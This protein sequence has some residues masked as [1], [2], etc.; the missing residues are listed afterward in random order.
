MRHHKHLVE[1][2]ATL[3]EYHEAKTA[4]QQAILKYEEDEKHEVARRKE[5]IVKWLSASD[6]STDQDRGVA[7][8]QDHA[9]SGKWLLKEEKYRVWS[10][11]SNTCLPLLWIN[12]MPGAGTLVITPIVARLIAS[13]QDSA[14]FGRDRA[15][16]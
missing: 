8:R 6:S 12:G 9:E 14:G 11:P 5:Y 7:A 2:R 13:R 15:H 10:G 1:T 4:R 16:Q 3:A